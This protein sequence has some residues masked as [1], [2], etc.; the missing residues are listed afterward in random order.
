[1]DILCSDCVFSTPTYCSKSRATFP[2]ATICGD[3][4]VVHWKR[5]IPLIAAPQ[6][7]FFTFSEGDKPQCI[8]YAYLP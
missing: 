1:M 8:A 7:E 2:K 6:K 3:Y 4:R 5:Q